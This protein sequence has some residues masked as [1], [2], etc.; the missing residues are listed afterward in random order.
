MSQKIENVSFHFLYILLCGKHKFMLFVS[1]FYLSPML[2]PLSLSQNAAFYQGNTSIV[3]YIE[4]M[5]IYFSM[6]YMY[7]FY[8][9]VVAVCVL[10][11]CLTFFSVL[12]AEVWLLLIWRRETCVDYLTRARWTECAINKAYIRKVKT[13]W[14]ILIKIP[15]LNLNFQDSLF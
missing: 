8:N 14:T 9:L 12:P 10:P 5:N 2:M 1:D 15:L 3:F 6:I 11:F 7:Y 4:W 13:T